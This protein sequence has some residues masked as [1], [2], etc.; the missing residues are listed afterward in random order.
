MVK[1][2]T[3]LIARQPTQGMVKEILQMKE[4]DTRW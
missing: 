4:N 3:E 2:K 1:E